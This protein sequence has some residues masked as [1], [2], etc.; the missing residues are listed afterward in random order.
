MSVLQA[1]AMAQGTNGTAAL[2]KARLLRK[3]PNGQEETPINLKQVL[4]SK[5]PNVA[6]Q[7]EDILFVPGSATKSAGRKT[8]DAIL[9][10]ATGA[11]IYRP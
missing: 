8:L 5:A 3:T 9:Q 7:P 4:A 2:S 10:A 1:I 11:A 6:L